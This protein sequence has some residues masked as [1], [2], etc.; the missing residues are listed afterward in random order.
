M[1]N[2]AQLMV[3]TLDR[4]LTGPAE[5]R[6]MGG[7]ALVLAYDMQRGTEDIDLLM[8]NE[9]LELLVQQADLGDALAATNRELEPHGLYISH[10]WGPE[11]QI[12]TPQWR[13]NCRSIHLSGLRWLRLSALGPLDLLVS[14]LCRADDGDLADIAHLIRQEELSPTVIRRA[15]EEAVVPE[16]F[17]PTYSAGIDKVNELLCRME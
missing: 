12:L 3:Q 8:E 5:L 14:K 11:Q 16:V 7:A 13:A 9:E 6:L 17:R 10:I 2:P 15:M 4:Y 1:A